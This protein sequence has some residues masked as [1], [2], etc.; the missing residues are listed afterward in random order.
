MQ[1]ILSSDDESSNTVNNI[2]GYKSSDGQCSHEWDWV[3]LSK[4]YVLCER[5][6]DVTSKNVIVNAFMSV[7]IDRCK[8]CWHF[9]DCKDIN[10]IYG[11]TVETNPLRQLLVDLYVNYG[12][13]SELD[14]ELLPKKFIYDVMVGM[15]DQGDLLAVPEPPKIQKYLEPSGPVVA[16]SPPAKRP[17]REGYVYNFT[18]YE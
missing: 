6:Q 13:N 5:L 10:I 17:R 8:N 15:F 16:R 4:L 9:P 18:R 2:S 12:N 14:Y 11:G 7:S 1:G 3:P